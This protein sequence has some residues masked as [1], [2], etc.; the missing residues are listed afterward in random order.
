MTDHMT[1][2]LVDHMIDSM[3]MFM[4]KRQVQNCDVKAVS[5]CC[6]ASFVA[7]GKCN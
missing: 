6:I 5:H 2:H 3:I 1:D 7:A 4:T